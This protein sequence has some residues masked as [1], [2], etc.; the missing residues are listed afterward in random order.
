MPN[1]GG[2]LFYKK[3]KETRPELSERVAFVSGSISGKNLAFIQ[4]EKRPYLLIGFGRWGSSDPWLGIPVNWGQI[5]GAAGI[6]EAG[7]ENMNVDLS[8]GSHFFHN[9]TSFCVSYFSVPFTG[10]YKIDWEWL[11]K[12]PYEEDNE[13]V[14]HVELDNPMQ[15]KVDGHKGR[16]LISK[17]RRDSY[18]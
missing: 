6:V 3:L 7:L 11:M 15:I 9:L 14:R 12:M 8:Q 4:Q 18:E 2:I 5:S 13:F 16:G 17:H 10:K 1:I